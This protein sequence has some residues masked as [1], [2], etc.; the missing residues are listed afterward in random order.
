MK[1]KIKICILI[2]ILVIS[3]IFFQ[4]LYKIYLIAESYL[5]N[6]GLFKSLFIFSLFLIITILISSIPTSPF[7]F[8][9]GV[10]FGP[11]LGFAITLVAA[12]IGA[13]IAFLIGRL[14]LH[15]YFAK[16]FEKS[17]I[18]RK[19]LQEEHK[20]ILRFIFKSRLIP[21]MPLDL[22]SYM[23]GITTMP[24]WKFSL[25]TFL[26]MA[27]IVF[28]FTFFGHIFER[29]KLIIMILLFSTTII[30]SVYKIIK[31]KKYYVKGY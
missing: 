29:Y 17:K 16:R 5:I 2:A 18:Y 23:A 13:T 22:V 3:L 25:A 11:W 21:Q 27:P 30:Y 7:A 14:F 9:A 15:D 31:Y 28:I 4:N 1:D 24:I 12:T 19:M 20:N 8:V 26:G 10:V 6:S